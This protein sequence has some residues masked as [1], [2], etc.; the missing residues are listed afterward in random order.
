[1]KK[2]LASVLVP[3]LLAACG[4]S[5]APPTTE[6][7]AATGALQCTRGGLTLAQQRAQLEGVGVAVVSAS[8]GLDG[9]ARVAVCG[10]S[11]GSIGVFTIASAQTGVALNNGF[12]LFASLPNGTKTAC[13]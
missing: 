6:V 5:D 9:A 10:A 1:M 3:F 12:Q 2:T 13:R 7:Y 4:G 8:C 11:D